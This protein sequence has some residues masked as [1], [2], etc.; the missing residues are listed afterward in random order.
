MTLSVI[1][2]A[3]NEVSHID[4]LIESISLLD[5]TEKE[6]LI[7]D[8][9][10]TDGTRERVEEIARGQGNVRLVTNPDRYVSQGFNRAFREARGK[11][12]S[13][14]GAHS[15][16]PQGY[17]TNCIQEIEAGTCDAAGGFL[18]HRGKTLTGEA[19]S[20][21]MSSQFGVGNTEFRT[22]RKKMYVDSVAFAVYDREVFE[23]IGLLDEDLVR[24]QDDEFHYRLNQAGF[25][26]LMLPEL[27][28]VYYVRDSLAKLF[29][30]YYQYGFYKP[31][32]FHKVRSGVRSR[33]LIPSLFVF[34]LISLPLAFFYPLLAIPLLVYFTLAM[35]FSIQANTSWQVRL[36]MPLVYPILHI[37]YGWGFLRGLWYWQKKNGN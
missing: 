29:S 25:R 5:R 16:Y 35:G 15:I 11:Y 28:I 27:E 22:I 8:G 31:M 6:I 36:R 20:Q 12:I 23:T 37:A 21:C 7:V 9:G 26:I 33:H 10:S 18:L 34:Y 2:P 17:F 13:L 3:L 4:Q 14:I 24:N 32:V 19:I 30:Q 1:I